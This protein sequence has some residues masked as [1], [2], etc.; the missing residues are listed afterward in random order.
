MQ[1]LMKDMNVPSKNVHSGFVNIPAIVLIAIILLLYLGYVAYSDKGFDFKCT[2]QLILDINNK[3]RSGWKCIHYASIGSDMDRLSRMIENGSNLNL[4]TLEGRTPLYLSA[5]YGNLNALK[6]LQ[7][8]G[9]DLIARDSNIGFTSLHV[10]AEYKHPDV[11]KYLISQGVDV[12]ITNKWGQTPLMQASWREWNQGDVIIPLLIKSGANINAK[13]RKGFTALH[14]A[15]KYGKIQ[16]VGYLLDSGADINIKTNDGRT[17]LSSAAKFDH[18][19]TVEYLVERGAKIYT[20][21][22]RWSAL[23]Y[24]KKNENA[25]MVNL[26]LSYGA[27][28]VD[29]EEV[30]TDQKAGYDQL[31][32]GDYEEAI[33]DFNKAIEEDSS[34][35][36]SFYYRGNA[37]YKKQDYKNAALDLEKSIDLNP[38]NLE[39]LDLLAWVYLQQKEMEKS[40]E[41]Y[42]QLIEV[43]PDNGKA[44]H[45]RAGINNYLGLQEAALDDVRIACEKGYNDGC[46]MYK[47]LS[48]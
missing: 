26:L 35:D 16:M 36:K 11:V 8:A 48:Q 5:K 2:T 29:V 14:R 40:K 19:E 46:T 32:G 4:R 41:I 37:H 1:S 27:I 13:S 30:Y 42:T 7:A 28:D 17:P 20:S 45:N 10:S 38:S 33:V 21:T 24:A 34:N 12:N 18:L 22:N 23:D 6:L 44:Y 31:K 3:D 47:R 39:S 25:E 15:T 9:D 43:D